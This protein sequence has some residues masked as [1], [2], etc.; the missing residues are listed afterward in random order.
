MC[1]MILE[2]VERDPMVLLSALVSLNILVLK[3]QNNILVYV[4]QKKSLIYWN[5]PLEIGCLYVGY[6]VRC[7]PKYT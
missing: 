1:M 3:G 4:C 6:V 5:L 2:K 7:T